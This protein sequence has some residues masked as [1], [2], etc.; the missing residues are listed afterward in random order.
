MPI[1]KLILVSPDGWLED[2]CFQP[3]ESWSFVLPVQML[4]L[5]FIRSSV[6]A[7]LAVCWDCNLPW[8]YRYNGR[9]TGA[10]AQKMPMFTSGL[11][12][13][14]CQLGILK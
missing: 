3:G 9:M 2:S 1:S 10:L 6:I 4:W 8:K 7:V 14:S 11:S 13:G 12:S 5:G